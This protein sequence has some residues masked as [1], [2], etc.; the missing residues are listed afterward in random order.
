MLRKVEQLVKDLQDDNAKLTEAGVAG[1]LCGFAGVACLGYGHWIRLPFG[2]QELERRRKEQTEMEKVR[3]Q[4]REAV[5]EVR[6][7]GKETLHL[8]SLHNHIK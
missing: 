2:P 3:Q 5:S 4:K 7:K 6:C 1:R 8:Q